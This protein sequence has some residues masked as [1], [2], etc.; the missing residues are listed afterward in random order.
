MYGNTIKQWFLFHIPVDDVPS[1]ESQ[2][3]YRTIRFTGK[4]FMDLKVLLM[5]LD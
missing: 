2:L 4:W 1:L 5:T 3:L